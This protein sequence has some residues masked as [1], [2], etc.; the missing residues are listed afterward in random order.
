MSWLLLFSICLISFRI[1]TNL[2]Y[3]CDQFPTSHRKQNISTSNWKLAS[4]Q[5][6]VVTLAAPLRRSAPRV[7]ATVCARRDTAARGAT[8]ARPA[9]GATPTASPASVPARDPPHKTE[10]LCPH[11]CIYLIMLLITR[12]DP[13]SGQCPCRSNFGGRQCGDCTPGNYDYPNCFSKFKYMSEW[14]VDYPFGLQ[15]FLMDIIVL[16]VGENSKP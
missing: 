9:G 6:V 15:T 3:D 5:R 2:E 14:F 11:I 16:S 8:S 12:C 1:A 7:W 10:G 4:F 13:V